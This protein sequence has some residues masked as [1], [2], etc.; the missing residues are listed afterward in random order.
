MPQTILVADDSEVFRV[1]EARILSARG[2]QI[3]HAANGA[4]AL[5]KTIEDKP[6]LVLLDVQMPVMDGVQVLSALKKDPKTK[7]IPVIVVTT[8]GRDTDREILLEGGAD[9]FLS[10]PIDSRKL[11][12]LIRELL[13]E[14][15]V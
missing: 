1:L 12:S 3:I 14:P 15:L 9:G 6:D 7:P 4:E 8:L 10:K 5:R 11:L 2:Y 13:G